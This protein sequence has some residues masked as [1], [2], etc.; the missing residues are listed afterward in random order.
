MS[1][2]SSRARIEPMQNSPRASFWLIGAGVALALPGCSEAPT[3]ASQR[4]GRLSAPLAG[5]ETDL[6]HAGVLAIITATERTVELCTGTLI[7][8]N[9]VLT[10]RH[11]VAPAAELVDCAT[12]LFEEPY[13]ASSVW[14]NRTAQ[15][16]GPLF[17]FGLLGTPAGDEREFFSVAEVQ[18][19]DDDGFVCG[20]DVALLILEELVL[21]DAIPSIEP[22]LDQPVLEREVYDAVGFGMTP[23]A[24]ELGTRRLKQDLEVVCGMDDCQLTGNGAGTEFVGGDG[25]CSGDSGGP[26][27]SEDGRVMGV[28]SRSADCDSPVYT[29]LSPWRDWIREV[30]TRAARRGGYAGPDWLVAEQL[31]ELDGI[32]TVEE[33]PALP[34]IAEPPSEDGASGDDAAAGDAGSPE[35]PEGEPAAPESVSSDSGGGAGCSLGPAPAAPRS[36]V[37]L[38]LLGS[39]AIGLSRRRPRSS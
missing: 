28:A 21:Q 27:L 36:F 20:G 31:D 32:P 18:V 30:A 35:N 26:A 25:V 1:W 13:T 5:A 23:L 7:A 12:S 16:S 39:A 6:G 24:S 29:A 8:P 4:L 11:C 9:L 2:A 37:S 17:S 14:V 3:Q 38:L 34:G 33:R 19:P 10:A 22:R 15:L